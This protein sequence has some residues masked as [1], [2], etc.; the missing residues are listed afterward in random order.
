VLDPGAIFTAPADG[1]YVLGI[2]DTRGLAGAD[3]TYRVEI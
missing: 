3:Y 1:Q 2:E